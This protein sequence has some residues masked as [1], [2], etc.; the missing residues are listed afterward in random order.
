[1]T[2]DFVVEKGIRS[3]PEATWRPVFQRSVDAYAEGAIAEGA[4]ACHVILDAVG[5]P[6]RIRELTYQNQFWYARPLH[7]IV[8]GSSTQTLVVPVPG[9]WRGLDPSPVVED[10]GLTVVLRAI[11]DAAAQAGDLEWPSPEGIG[12]VR[13]RLI[14]ETTTDGRQLSELRPFVGPEGLQVAMIVRIGMVKDLRAPG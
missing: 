3:I 10:T 14:P 5:L 1:M 6:E 12:D 4:E 7:E 11:P 9:G 8:P 13:L 2:L